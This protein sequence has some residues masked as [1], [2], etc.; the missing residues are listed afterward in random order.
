MPMIT[1][2]ERQYELDLLS[3]TTK[4]QLASLQFVD[5]EIQKIQARLAV[6]QTAR[7]AYSNALKAALP[8][9]EEVVVGS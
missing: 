2:D 4:E 7:M 1:I 5:A 6:Y 3:S 8:K 9:M